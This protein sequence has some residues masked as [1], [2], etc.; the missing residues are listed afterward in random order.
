MTAERFAGRAGMSAT[1]LR[2]IENGDDDADRQ[3]G[4]LF[5]IDDAVGVAP[6]TCAQILEGDLDDF[7]PPPTPAQLELA[8]RI[9]ALDD[10]DADLLSVIV[11]RFSA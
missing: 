10:A 11:R 1:T 3:E 5:K 7:P 2:G 8:R 4:T 9:A 6:G